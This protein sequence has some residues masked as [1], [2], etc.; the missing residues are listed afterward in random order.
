MKDA[1]KVVKDRYPHA[2]GER[3]SE[4]EWAVWDVSKEYQEALGYVNDRYRMRILI[5]YGTTEA[6]A[7]NNA[8]LRMVNWGR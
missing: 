3:Y 6:A 4:K 7:W 2:S 8:A 1:K 5:G